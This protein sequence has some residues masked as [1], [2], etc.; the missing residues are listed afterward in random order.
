MKEFGKRQGKTRRFAIIVLILA[1]LFFTAG[2]QILTWYDLT[3]LGK[4]ADESLAFTQERVQTFTDFTENDKVKSLYRLLDKTTELSRQIEHYGADHEEF[5][6]QYVYEQRMDGVLILDGELGCVMQTGELS[7]AY[8]FWKDTF[9]SDTVCDI[10]SCPKKSFVTRM[11]KE[12]ETY[13]LAVVSRQD[14]KGLVICYVQKSNTEGMDGDLSMRKLLGGFTFEMKGIAVVTDGQRIV[15]TNAKRLQPQ[16]IDRCRGLYEGSF[17]MD[18]HGFFHV[19]GADESWYGRTKRMKGYQIYVCFPASAVFAFR[20]KVLLIGILSCLTVWILFSQFQERIVRSNMRQLEKQYRTIQSISSIYSFT[21]LMNLK[22][23]KWELLK[24]PEETR[25][26]LTDRTT[27]AELLRVFIIHR[28]A[29]EYREEY[30]RFTDPETLSDRLKSCSYLTCNVE[31]TSHGWDMSGIIP[32]KYDESGEVEEVFL[33]CRDITEEKCRETD[34]QK[35]LK[36]TAEQAERANI[37][38]TDFLRRMSH[39]VRTPI[40]GIRGMV[41]IC[42][43]YMGDEK[44]QTECLDKIMA[45]SGFLLD[46]VNDALDMNKLESG[47]IY[48]EHKPFEL[49]SVLQEVQTMIETQAREHGIQF[50][51][52]EIDICHEHLLGSVLHLRQILQNLVS[53][54]V[55]Y[56]KPGGA[57]AV[58]C[59]ET[60]CWEGKSAVME[61]VIADTGQGMSREFQEH[62]F[63]PFA[64]EKDTARTDYQGTGLGLAITKKLVEQ[65]KG[66][67][68][69]VSKQGAGTTFTVCIPFDVDTSWE[70]AKPC[71]KVPMKE[72]LRGLRVLVVEDNQTNM[73]IARFMLEQAGAEVFEAYDG[74]EALEVLEQSDTDTVDVVLMDIMM[75]VMNG[76][77]AAKRIRESPRRDIRGVIIIAM[78]ANA[79]ADD[80]QRS[81]EAGMNYHLSKPIELEQVVEA[82]AQCRM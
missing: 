40:N 5:L 59:R 3:R 18:R 23:N 57:V 24:A 43:Y 65:M 31:N 75:P 80:V 60:D 79:F 70:K 76:L 73:E 51:V 27:I 33:L 77:E 26:L 32:Q 29:P 1:G 14:A 52:Q 44:K 48:L 30:T 81:Y 28:I 37:A 13:D 19:K 39:D 42:R 47:Q 25:E 12:G 54:A 9:C 58:R 63:E 69:F 10:I 64:Q 74:K 16:A 7:D 35:R 21:L 41:Q 46:L 56:N 49:F 8:A 15:T 62:A 72:A 6:K 17:V 66:S 34:Y 2:F 36:E 20:T 67:I 45:S 38:K 4:I 82:V 61:F 50:E 55:K 22:E 71:G 53:N 68:R 78:S 11:E